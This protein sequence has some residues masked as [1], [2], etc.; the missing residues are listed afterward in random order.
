[1]YRMRSVI[2]R[3]GNSQGVSIP[4]SILDEA[5]LAI[6][7]PIDIVV[8]GATIVLRKLAVHPREGW[9]AD[10]ALVTYDDED[11]E[12]LEADL[13]SEASAKLTWSCRRTN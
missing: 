5:G 10:A 6:N 4:K 9:A 7:S 11:R 8:D 3:L 13:D 2:R 1:M 12:W